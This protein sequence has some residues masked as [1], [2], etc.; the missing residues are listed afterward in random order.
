M[1]HD[2]SE[3]FKSVTYSKWETVGHGICVLLRGTT[4]TEHPA[5]NGQYIEHVLLDVRSSVN[6][7]EEYRQMEQTYADGI[8]TQDA[9]SCLIFVS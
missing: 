8:E 1:G 6:N 2:R 9:L 5:A 4:T 7:L 3:N